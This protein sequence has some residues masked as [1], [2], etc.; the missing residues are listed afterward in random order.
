MSLSKRLPIAFLV[1]CAF[2]GRSPAQIVAFGA[3]NVAGAGVESGQAWPAQ[4]EALLREKGYNV[5][6]I[7]AGITGDTTT[8]MLERVDSS[9]PN[10]TKIVVL[11][12][13]GGFF[14][15]ERVNISHDQGVK[16]M[17][18]IAA[19]LHARGIKIVPEF[20]NRMPDKFKQ[21]DKIHLTAAGHRELAK[22]LLPYVIKAL[23]Q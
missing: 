4:L 2:V 15:D 11:D 9:I 3:S 5:N 8:H 19:R 23:T 7:N 21:P 12:I 13:G 16:D 17:R 10:G 1:L 18:A 22:L 14:N 20:A 6:V